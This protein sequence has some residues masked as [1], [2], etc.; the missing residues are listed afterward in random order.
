MTE[1]KYL[2]VDDKGDGIV[3]VRLNRPPA[4]AVD[5]DMYIEIKELFS[6]VDRVE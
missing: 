4:N 3:N 1:F 5:R 2:L 6:N